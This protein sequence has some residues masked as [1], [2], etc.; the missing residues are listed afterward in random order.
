[1]KKP[2]YPWQPRTS[3]L[4]RAAGT[5]ATNVDHDEVVPP[6][7]DWLPSPVRRLWRRLRALHRAVF[8]LP[9]DHEE[10][11]ARVVGDGAFTGRYGFMVV[12][13]CAIATLGLLLS[14]PAVIIGAMLIS[15]LMGPIM[16]FGFS[17][18]LLDFAAFRRSAVAL[19]IG[20]GLALAI[21]Y[22]IVT[23]SPLTQAT[24]EILART[25]PNLFDLL[26]AVFSGLAG[27]YAVINK[28]GETIVGVAIATALMPP[29]A[30]VGYGLASRTPQIAAGAWFLFMTNLLAIALSATAL[31][32]LYGFA[33]R[34]SRTKNV[35][36]VALM[37]VVFGGLSIPLGI[38]LK[39][40]A[41]EARVSRMTRDVLED[42]LT[43]KARLGELAVRFTADGVKIDAVALTKS[44]DAGAERRLQ[45]ALEQAVGQSV[46]LDLDQVLVDQ[47]RPLDPAE[48]LRLAETSLT[49]P[50][51]A[52][53][54][55]MTRRDQLTEDFRAVAPFKV[56]AVEADTQRRVA[57]LY[58]G[59]TKHLDFAAYREIETELAARYP[60][61][62][63]QVIP[64][65]Q[66]LPPVPFNL[67]SA[68]L[69]Q[70]ARDTL[71]TI[72]WT[73]DRWGVTQVSATGYASTAGPR[74]LNRSLAVARA[75][76]VADF[77]RAHGI[78]TLVTGEFRREGQDAIER[79]YGL[80]RFHRVDVALIPIEAPEPR[81][82]PAVSTTEPQYSP[83]LDA[84]A[85]TTTTSSGQSNH[86]GRR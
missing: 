46:V 49:A 13:A 62:R 63:M 5:P 10:V 78:E 57:T 23:L 70:A 74:R 58:A 12:M 24:P 19:V 82:A 32:V 86:S 30:V 21:S 50:L 40:I 22:G 35:W 39:K 51:Q 1:M 83:A 16:L 43:G 6:V 26:V 42:G 15:P 60:T 41:Y 34:Q 76:N 71:D 14:S 73:L 48:F 84:S 18:A 38:S 36:R 2:A 31:A 11:E 56:G 27:A 64:P 3:T 79:L 55:Q 9:T 37:I 8:V 72:H 47:D 81:G 33:A 53:I 69:T 77:L 75:Q 65:P 28:K 66:P 45:V 61:W 85:V 80:S 4:S 59:P 52:Q 7:G 25:R 54:A 20:I 29:L 68:S 67:G 44:Y 17:L